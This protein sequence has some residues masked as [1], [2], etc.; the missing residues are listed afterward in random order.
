MYK[1]L[2]IDDDDLNLRLMSAMLGHFGYDVYTSQRG[3]H[4]IDLAQNVQPDIILIDLLMPKATY[5]GVK[6]V[7]AL[8]SVS[9]FQMTPII[10]VSAADSQTIQRLLLQGSFTDFIQKPITIDK[11]N[12]VLAHLDHPDIA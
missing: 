6:C 10:A 5:D 9:Q 8:R 11:L 7:Q 4:G 1:A 3:D 2:I 12:Q